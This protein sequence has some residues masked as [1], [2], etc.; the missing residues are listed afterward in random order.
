M[1]Q[2]LL[3]TASIILLSASCKKHKTVKPIDQLP[4]ETQTGANTFGCLVNGQAFKPAGAQ[5]MGGALQCNYQFVN[6]AYYFVLV[7]RHQSTNSLLTSV[8]L[9]TDSLPIQT[10]NKLVL[11]MRAKGNPSGDYFKALSASQYE[12][13]ETNGTSY[14]GELCVKKFDSINQIISGTFWFDAVNSNGQ[15]VEVREGRFDVHYTR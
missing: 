3:I 15:K 5:L 13:Y 8:G 4:P 10:D 9:Y 6:S 11:K 7:G 1:K 14:I 2:L 12:Q